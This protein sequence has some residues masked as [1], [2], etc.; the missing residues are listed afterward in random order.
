MTLH[1]LDYRLCLRL[2]IK[3]NSPDSWEPRNG[4]SEKETRAPLPMSLAG[5]QVQLWKLRVYK[6]SLLAPPLLTIIPVEP[7]TKSRPPKPTMAPPPPRTGS[8]SP[9][10]SSSPAR[11]TDV[12]SK[13]PKRSPSPLSDAITVKIH[14]TSTRAI[15]ISKSTNLQKLLGLVC[16]KFDKQEG[17]LSIWWINN[18]VSY[19]VK[20][21][22]LHVHV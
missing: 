3:T 19:N 13:S 17:T 20:Q 8:R 10:H 15:R 9:T 16:R 2:L 5:V 14:Y 21:Y 22:T 11:D 18:Y 7:K 1:F 4:K 12:R 6:Q